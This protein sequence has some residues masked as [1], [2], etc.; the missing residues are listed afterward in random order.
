MARRALVF[1]LIFASP[2][3]AVTC[4]AVSGLAYKEQVLCPGSSTCCGTADACQDNRLCKNHDDD[5]STPYIRGPCAEKTYDPAKCGAIC[6]YNE[7]EFH[8]NFFP[9][10]KKCSDGSF[11]CSNEVSCCSRGNGVFLAAN[12][13]IVDKSSV[14]ST[15]ST[16]TGTTQSISAASTTPSASEPAPESAPDSP[17]SASRNSTTESTA[18][19][20]GLGLGIPLAAILAGL[21]AWYILKRRQR[22]TAPAG[23]QVEAPSTENGTSQPYHANT[24]PQAGLS[25]LSAPS[26]PEKPMTPELDATPVRRGR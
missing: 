15:T 23:P 13:D 10:V 12:G 1:F 17:S 5:G 24:S 7:T 8:N 22:A 14:S 2:A 19:K 25:E 20:V 26:R 3:L 18:W 4:F 11:C 9:R 6:V 16:E 21:G